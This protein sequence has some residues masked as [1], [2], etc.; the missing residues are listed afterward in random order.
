[1]FFDPRSAN[2]INVFISAGLMASALSAYIKLNAVVIHGF[3]KEQ[4]TA[5]ARCQKVR[6]MVAIAIAVIVVDHV[7]TH[8]IALLHKRLKFINSFC[9]YH[10]F[11][12]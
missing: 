4:P 7:Q 9:N 2:S 3:C 11:F 6:G 10:I 5:S 1:L 8:A 12:F